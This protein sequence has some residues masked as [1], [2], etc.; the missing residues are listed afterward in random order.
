MFLS[1]LKSILIIKNINQ[2]IIKLT[3]KQMKKLLKF[4]VIIFSFL[5]LTSCATIF[6][7]TKQKVMIESNPPGAEI[8]VDG[9]KIG[10]T[11]SKVKLERELKAFSDGKKDIQLVL[12]GYKSEGYA[13]GAELNPV[14]IFN[15]FNV[16]FWGLDALTGAV[17]KYDKVNE[18]EMILLDNISITPALNLN[19]DKY[20]K[21]A[22]LKKLYD[23]GVLNQE[24]F[25]TEKAKILE[26]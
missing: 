22:Q 21:L 13:V 1:T 4:P 3:L 19:G 15:L 5:L 7:G 14:A 9:K 25:E 11:P 16:A 2:T 23:E 18:F 8:L 20:D 17:T 26:E 24:E 10:Q 12:D 6:T